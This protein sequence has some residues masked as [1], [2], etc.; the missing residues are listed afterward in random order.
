MKSLWSS[1]PF[2]NTESGIRTLGR[3]VS[4]NVEGASLSS[5]LSSERRILST[6]EGR[7]FEGGLRGIFAA[8]D[9][10]TVGGSTGGLR[11][12][13]WCGGVAALFVKMGEEKE[14]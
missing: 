11:E 7:W 5:D 1:A 2:W 14:G 3:P 8:R 6:S 9:S 12:A 13:G 10:G 4:E